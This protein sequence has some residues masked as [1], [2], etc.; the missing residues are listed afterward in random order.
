M[1][2]LHIG[3]IPDG[4]RRWAREQGL[5][6]WKGHEEGGKRVEELARHIIKNYPEVKSVT[7]WAFSSEN[8]KRSLAERK[9]IFRLIKEHIERLMKSEEIHENQVKIRVVGSEFDDVPDSL[10]KVAGQAMDLTKD[11][12]KKIL[13]IAVG[14][15]GKRDI[16]NAVYRMAN[17]LLKAGKSINPVKVFESFLE[18]KEPFDMIIRTGGEKRLSGFGSYNLDYA[19]LFFVDKYW[20][21]VH[22]EDFD[23]LMEEFKERERR[24]GG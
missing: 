20:P 4:N 24:Y 12:S 5:D 11:Y 21:D 1:D 7:F 16:N 8:F 2:G 13:N 23:K 22:A 14:Y 15:G 6:D 10:K 18:V 9:E 19:E 3:I 17:W